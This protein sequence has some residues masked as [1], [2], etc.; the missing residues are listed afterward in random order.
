MVEDQ[1]AGQQE[2][3]GADAVGL[4]Y[5][6]TVGDFASALRAR[7]GVSRASRRQFWILGCFAVLLALQIAVQMSG[8]KAA[9]FP[10]YI[11]IFV[12]GILI[13]LTPWLQARQFHR[14]AERLGTFRVTVTD[15]GVTVIS[16]NT[17]ASVNWSAQPRY[18]ETADVFVMLSPDKNAVAFTMLPKRALAAPADVDRLRTL[19]DRNLTRV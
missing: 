5:R 16:D 14:F 12:Y 13:L 9:P 18:R 15:T 10:L 6:P 17:T 8:G 3:R 2:L 1:G 19:L 4:E 11:G 7:R